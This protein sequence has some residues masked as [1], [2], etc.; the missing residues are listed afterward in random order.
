MKLHN[1]VVQIH[2][3][4]KMNV[5]YLRTSHEL[6]EGVVVYHIHVCRV[7]CRDLEGGEGGLKEKH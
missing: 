3:V 2:S 6:M 1:Q 7:G 5:N 4:N